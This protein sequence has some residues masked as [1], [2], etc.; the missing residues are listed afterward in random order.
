MKLAILLL[1]LC[2]LTAFAGPRLRITPAPWKSVVCVTVEAD[3]GTKLT[4]QRSAD[5]RRWTDIETVT[6]GTAGTVD[7][8][9]LNFGAC[10]FYRVVSR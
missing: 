3:P 8:Y 5:L 6:V 4:V 10:A 9:D 1:L 2:C 7:V